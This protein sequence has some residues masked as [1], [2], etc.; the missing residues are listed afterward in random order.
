[1]YELAT[2]KSRQLTFDKKAIPGVCWAPNGQIIFS[3]NKTGNFNLWTIPSTGG[4][5]TQV[6]TGAGPDYWMSISRDGSK[7]LYLQ[8]QSVAHI[9]IAGTDGSTP[10]QVT[11]DDAHLWRVAFSP[12]GKEVLFGF[13]PPAGFEKGALV[14]SID[15]EGRNRKQLTAGEETISNPIMSPDGRWIIYGR[16]ALS[17]PS[18]SSMVYL[19]DAKNPGTPRRVGKGAPML[20]VDE[21]T[22]I[23]WEMYDRPMSWLYSIE[24]GEPKQ[25]FEDSTSAIPLQGGKYVGYYDHRAGREGIWVCAAPGT[26]DPSTPS[27][28][29]IASLFEFG[30]F[31]KRGEFRYWVKNAGEL[32]R[33][34]IPSGKEEIIPGVFPGLNYYGSWFDIS[35]DGKEIVYTD[36]R[37]NS[38]LVLIEKVFK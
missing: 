7:L 19:I 6:T 31:D 25:F 37:E 20:W 30:E 10:R 26:K 38:K 8:Q 12:D 28:R 36:A 14:C 13:V 35:Y 11:F 33:I 16:H 27:P 9:W 1:V 24:G 34:S 4:S 21:K 29:R 15:R 2:G 18:D 32:R 22:F 3:S 5:A 23:S 17:A